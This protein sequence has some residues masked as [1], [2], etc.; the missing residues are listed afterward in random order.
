MKINTAQLNTASTQKKTSPAEG[1]HFA[2]L[3]KNARQVP[4]FQNIDAQP[5]TL[6]RSTLARLPQ[7]LKSLNPVG[8]LHTP[9]PGA[10]EKIGSS[11]LS[12]PVLSSRQ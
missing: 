9:Q 12:P 4:T 11:R 2:Q 8:E 3:L 6:V 10:L 7:E 5:A 1:S